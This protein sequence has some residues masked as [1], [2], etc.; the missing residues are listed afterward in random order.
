MQLEQQKETSSWM[1]I[2]H[3]P[4]TPADLLAMVIL[5]YHLLGTASLIMPNKDFKMRQPNMKSA[6]TIMQRTGWW[7][8]K[9]VAT[10]MKWYQLMSHL[11]NTAAALTW[12]DAKEFG[13]KPLS[14]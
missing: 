4:A 11:C 12:E 10:L 7:L 1:L 13:S 6:N 8:Q 9:L 3:L 5:P 2:N 14:S